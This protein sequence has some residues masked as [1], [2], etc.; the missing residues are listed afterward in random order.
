MAWL[1]VIGTANA[2]EVESGAW[3]MDVYRP[4]A[5]IEIVQLDLVADDGS[6][7]AT[8][9]KGGTFLVNFRV[10]EG[11]IWFEHA[12]FDESCR[13]VRQREGDWLGTCPPNQ[14]LK[15]DE[16][17]TITL[18]PPPAGE[19]SRDASFG[20]DE[21]SADSEEEPNEDTDDNQGLAEM[22]EDQ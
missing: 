9:R 18:H 17:L 6:Y 4:D 13:L 11:D 12:D 7:M 3:T 19:P 2:Q 8:I 5:P 22:Q 16:G 14:E 10:R 1:A 15:F 20:D 21:P